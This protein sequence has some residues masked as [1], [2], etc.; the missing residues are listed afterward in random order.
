MRVWV[1]IESPRRIKLPLGHNHAV[2]AFIYKLLSTEFRNFLHDNGFSAGNRKMKLFTFSRLYGRFYRQGSWLVY[3]PPVT[4]CISSPV[5]RFVKEV[6]NGLIRNSKL[7]LLGNELKVSS[8]NFPKKPKFSNEVTC[9]TLSPITVYSTLTTGDGRKK[10]YYYSPY[11]EEFS[12]IISQ[13]LAR[14][15][16]I[17]YGRN[18]NGQVK[19][20][21]EHASKPR[22]NIILFK[23][24]VIKGWT[25]TFVLKGNK[26]LIEAGYE[27]GLGNKNPEGFGM[28]EVVEHA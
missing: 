8:L 20:M 12:L 26:K 21:L 15:A 10:T 16:S 14:K 1:T 5:E 25:G 22:E 11:E 3:D 18:I 9:K 2:Q 24:T 4:L 17:L 23:N 7:N 27:A 13:N 6:T 28:I 19:I